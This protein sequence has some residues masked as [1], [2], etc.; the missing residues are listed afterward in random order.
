[1]HEGA[2]KNP[3]NNQPTM[4]TCVSMLGLTMVAGGNIMVKSDKK[5][6]PHW[7]YCVQ[8]TYRGVADKFSSKMEY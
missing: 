7:P 1:M 8:I 6:V 5:K 3:L 4:C 2:F